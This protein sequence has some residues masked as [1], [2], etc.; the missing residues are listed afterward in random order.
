MIT[1]N[2][3][4]GSEEW[5]EYRK[6]GIGGSE[7]ASAAKI[8][9][10]FKTHSQMLHEKIYGA[11]APSEFLQKLFHDGHEWEIVVRDNLN[12]NGFNFVPLVAVHESNERLFSSLDGVD[13]SKEIVLE[14]KSCST[15]SKFNEYKAKTPKHYMAQ[16]Q[17]AL[18]VTKYSKAMIAYV[19]AGEVYI[20][21]IDA[22]PLFQGELFGSA[23]DFL[24]TLDSMKSNLQQVKKLDESG[25]LQLNK[26]VSLLQIEK[27]MKAQLKTMSA[28]VDSIAEELLKSTG[29]VR[30]EN[31]LMS[32]YIQERIGS[33]DYSKIPELENIDLEKYRKAAT[34]SIQTKLK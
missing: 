19:H 24:L 26:I 17:W 14:I 15:I 27:E 20:E 9:G 33:V 11:E 34:K 3:I 12:E 10:A 1:K 5:L 31:D 28:E 13:V 6:N 23:N 21:H 32:I 29:A 7:I 25:E 8:K 22:D 16:V 30:L 4:Q 18:F 2:L